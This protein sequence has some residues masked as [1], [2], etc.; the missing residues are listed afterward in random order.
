MRLLTPVAIWLGSLSWLPR[1]L[2]QIT[3]C[4]K[5]LQRW[6][7]G[8]W[9]LLGLAGLGSMML[10]VTGRKS[11]IPRSTPILCTPTD[12]GYLVAGSNFGGIAMPAWVFNVRAAAEAGQ[13]VVIRVDGRTSRA[14]PRELSGDERAAAWE[15]MLEMWPNYATYEERTDRVIPVFLMRP[16]D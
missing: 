9:S 14:H 12:G 16:I 10:T 11:G 7:K 6:T 13:E 8:R 15:R 5:Q 2:K 3:W 1:F 4:D